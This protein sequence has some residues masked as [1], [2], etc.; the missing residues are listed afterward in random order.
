[1]MNELTVL[2]LTAASVGMLHTLLGPD[3]YLPFIAMAK[4]GRWSWKK[5]ASVTTLCGLGHVGSTVVL[6]FVGIFFG[7]SLLHLQ[8][9]ESWRADAAGWLLIVFGL[10]YTAWGF[11]HAVHTRSDDHIPVSDPGRDDERID[12]RRAM[13]VWILFV[14]F[15]FGPCEPLI[16]VLMYPAATGTLSDV[17]IVCVVF[18]AATVGTMLLAVTAGVYGLTLIPIRRCARYSH[19]AAGAT[20]LTCGIA[21]R[22]LG[23]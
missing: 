19:A 5:T 22:F 23:A 14:I 12:D 1:M 9:I 8:T 10:I 11:R 16:P 17:V 7:Q 20:V 3:H 2:V 21:V 15:V 13:K 6:G 18:S 4:A